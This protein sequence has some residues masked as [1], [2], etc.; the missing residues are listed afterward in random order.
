MVYLQ[1]GCR[2]NPVKPC[3]FLH[4][5]HLSGQLPSVLVLLHQVGGIAHVVAAHHAI[6]VVH[7][8]SVDGEPTAGKQ[9][10]ESDPVDNAFNELIVGGEQHV[11][12]L[13]IP[14]PSPSRSVN[15]STSTSLSVSHLYL[16]A[17]WTTTQCV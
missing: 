15:F 17:K 4:L 11:F 3:Y 16:K 10:A 8:D 12:H 13:S 1:T 7:A 2:Q 14:M 5:A 6:G 9:G